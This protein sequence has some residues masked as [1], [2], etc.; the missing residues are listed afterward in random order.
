MSLWAGHLC[1]FVSGALLVHG[2]WLM[3]AERIRS[4]SERLAKML[5]EQ[6]ALGRAQNIAPTPPTEN[7]K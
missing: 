1:F 2:L 6:I 5:E 3:S 7:F 4:H